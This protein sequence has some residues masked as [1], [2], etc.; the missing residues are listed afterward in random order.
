MNDSSRRLSSWMYV[1]SNGPSA[2]TIA[3]VIPTPHTIRTI[4]E[5]AIGLDRS[6]PLS[7]V[8]RSVGASWLIW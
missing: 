4:I 5:A 3:T 7:E 6:G 2:A 8:R 1:A